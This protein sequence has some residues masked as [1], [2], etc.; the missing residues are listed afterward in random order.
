MNSHLG[1]VHILSLKGWAFGSTS[2]FILIELLYDLFALKIP[3]ALW[4]RL[5]TGVG[6]A[7]A[8]VLGL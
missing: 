8:P 4:G 7:L 5:L 6:L 3:F 1:I 2:I